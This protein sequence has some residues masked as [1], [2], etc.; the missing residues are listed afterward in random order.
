MRV[1]GGNHGAARESRVERPQMRAVKGDSRKAATT[2]LIADDD[3][4]VRSA[5]S[6]MVGAEKM[7]VKGQAANGEEAVEMARRLR[8]QVMLLDLVMPNMAGLEALRELK[9]S[10]P[11]MKTILLTMAIDKK[12][13]L[14]ALQLGAKGI[15]LKE[16]ARESL[17]AAIRTVLEGKYWVNK[18]ALEN[19]QTV[20]LELMRTV[21]Q[22]TCKRDLLSGKEQQIVTCIVEGCTNKEIAKMMQ[23][24]EQ[25]V[26]NHLGKI[27]DKLGVFNRLE[28]AL[29][30]LDNQ[31]AQRPGS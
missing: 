20:I 29:Y 15:V 30:A 21:E 19:V 2:V 8:P 3:P 6:L 16:S 22:R 25:V 4:L 14:Q 18:Q 28:L 5:I 12:Q 13:V 11:Q 27:F 26:K 7:E 1:E 23:T 9:D 24:S 17:P 31:L 10:V